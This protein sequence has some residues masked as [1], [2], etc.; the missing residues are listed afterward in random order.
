MHAD[1]RREYE[2][3]ALASIDDMQRGADRFGHFMSALQRGFAAGDAGELE[4][5]EPGMQAEMPTVMPAQGGMEVEGIAQGVQH[6]WADEA[7][8]SESDNIFFMRGAVSSGYR[9]TQ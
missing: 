9:M 6:A 4:P 8:S 5:G 7:S 1:A 3:R 2:H